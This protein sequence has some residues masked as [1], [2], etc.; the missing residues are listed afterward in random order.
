[1]LVDA[2]D[3][4]ELRTRSLV[5]EMQ[6]ITAGD[7]VRFAVAH[8]SPDGRH[9]LLDLDWIIGA[10][11]DVSDDIGR[12]ARRLGVEANSEVGPRHDAIDEARLEL[13]LDIL[14]RPTA[15]VLPAIAARDLAVEGMDAETPITEMVGLGLDR[16]E[17]EPC[18]LAIFG[19][20]LRFL[21]RVLEDR[22]A[23]RWANPC[24]PRRLVDQLS[25]P[26]AP[27]LR[28]CAPVTTRAQMFELKDVATMRAT[29]EAVKA[30]ASLKA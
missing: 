23:R 29:S 2:E 16:F 4:L 17:V 7:S 30:A 19:C 28:D 25:R 21:D 24:R 10:K 5:V 14:M 18:G 13:T 20:E 3:A 15:G 9:A 22:R 27:A 1:M 12:L 6:P 26:C 11:V 8:V